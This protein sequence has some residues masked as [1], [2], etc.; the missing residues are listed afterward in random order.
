MLW[1]ENLDLQTIVT[2]VDIDRFEQLLVETNYDKNETDF[3]IDGFRN[4]FSIGYE[5][6]EDVHMTANNLKLNVGN[7]TI[8]WNKVMKEVSKKRYAGP[9]EEIPFEEFIQSPIGL[10]PKDNGQDVRLIFHLSYP[11]KAKGE[12]QTS[13]N[14]NTPR[15]ACTVKYCDFDAAIK[16]CLTEGKSCNLGNQTCPQPSEI[17]E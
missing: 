16:L 9:F 6:K 7:E 12:E 3:L 4:G 1:F 10:V 13:L 14:A 8:L 15:D 5:G 2:P 17:W 11:R